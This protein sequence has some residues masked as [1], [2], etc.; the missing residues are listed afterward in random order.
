MSGTAFIGN[1]FSTALPL[2][3]ESFAHT[4][5]VLIKRRLKA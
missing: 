2:A 4:A 1:L 5:V 3:F